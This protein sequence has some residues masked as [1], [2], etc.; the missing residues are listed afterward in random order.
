M[1]RALLLFIAIGITLSLIT[2]VGTL[3]SSREAMVAGGLLPTSPDLARSGARSA[4]PAGFLLTP[5]ASGLVLP[6]DMAVMPDGGVLVAEKG[7]GFAHTALAN[8]KIVRD[9]Q[10]GSLP[11]LTLS[12]NS[13]GDSGVN[14]LVLDPDFDSNGY[15]YV[16]HATGV[17]SPGWSGISVFRLSR[18]TFNPIAETADPASEVIILDDVTWGFFHNG[19]GLA[20]GDDGYLYI[21]T[22]DTFKFQ[23][24]QQAERLRGKLLRIEPTDSGYTI[25]ADNPFV[26]EPG[27]REEIYALGL[28]NPFR[29]VKRQSDGQIYIADVGELTWEEM[30]VASSGAN[31]GWAVREGPCP[32]G[33]V[34]PCLPAGSEYTDPLLY[35]PHPAPLIGSAISAAAF[36]EGSS[37]PSIYQDNFVFGDINQGWLKTADLSSPPV[38]ESDFVTL[39]EAGIGIVDIENHEDN[40]LLLDIYSG[41]ILTLAYVGSPVP[42]TAQLAIDDPLGPAPHTVTFSGTLSLDP[43]AGGLLYAYDFDDGSPVVTTTNAIVT[44]TYT[45]DGN[46]S[47]LLHVKDNLD[48]KSAADSQALTVYS[49]EMPVIALTNLTEISRTL[50]HAGDT[51]QYEATRSTLADLDPISPFSWRIDLQ[52][53]QHLHPILVGNTVISATTAIPTD[54]HG[55]DVN[56]SYRF[57]LTMKTDTG[58]EVI[59]LTELFPALANVS[60]D[61][62]LYLGQQM[63]I[64][65]NHVPRSLPFGFPS[66]VGTLHEATAPLVVFYQADLYNFDNWTGQGA[67][68]PTLNFSTPEAGVMHI[69]N[70]L[71][72]GP[73]FIQYMPFIVSP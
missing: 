41:Q 7:T 68:N 58:I 38:V 18:F 15:F 28:R 37:F 63:V 4:P 9:G 65:L 31:L 3:A 46:F 20:F 48:L 25:P 39:L 51:I 49:G 50:Y 17:G 10:V 57:N 44:H 21:A 70:Y 69:V 36:Y 55:G 73:A 8:I 54:D 34:M 71:Y 67:P 2:P 27:Y 22:G 66:I 45:L 43:Q 24:A 52:H 6:I 42:P 60:I 11:V 33:E 62:N 26:G 56:L 19:G 53:N 30:S 32:F 14:G 23:F 61:S 16:W 35:Y 5:Y 29:I 64:E 59:V 40:L 1:K 13:S 12:T 47:P 72:S